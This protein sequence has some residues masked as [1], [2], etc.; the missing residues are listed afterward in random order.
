MLYSRKRY[1]SGSDYPFSENENSHSRKTSS[2]SGDEKILG[3][4][5]TLSERE[6]FKLKGEMTLL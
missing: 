3:Y 5:K 2:F 1:Y 4:S 6:L